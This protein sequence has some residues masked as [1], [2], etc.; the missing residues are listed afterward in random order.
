MMIALSSAAIITVNSLADDIFP[1]N[2]GAIFTSAGAPI[3]LPLP[4]PKCTLR[5][6]IAAANLNTSIGGGNGCIAG[7]VATDTVVFDPALN[8]ATVPG[9]RCSARQ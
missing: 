2:T 7:S 8:L 3:G 5:M 4:A 1:D 9:S 6:A